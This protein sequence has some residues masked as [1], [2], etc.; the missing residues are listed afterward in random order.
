MTLLARPRVSRRLRLIGA[1]GMLLCALA[2]Q[3]QP[4]MP[5]E[6]LKAAFVFNFAKYIEWPDEDGALAQIVACVMGDADAIGDALAAFHGRA[7][8]GRT[9]RVRRHVAPEDLDRC[10]IAVLS[11][12]SDRRVMAALQQVPAQAVLTVSDADGFVDGGGMIGIVRNGD[13]LQFDINQ[14]ALQRAKLKASSQ[15]LK[16]ARNLG[17]RPR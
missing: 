17:G 5:E 9:F 8:A 11:D 2:G 15:L 13:R 3:A 4:R 6:Q 12:S 14:S 7:V 10:H 16:L 1:V